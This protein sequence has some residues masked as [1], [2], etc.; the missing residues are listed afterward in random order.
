[1]LNDTPSD[2]LIWICSHLALS[3]V[4]SLVTVCSSFRKLTD[5]KYL[6]IDA[7]KSTGR[8]RSLACP[9]STD[10]TQMSVDELRRIAHRTHKLEYNWSQERPRIA[11]SAR[12]IQYFDSDSEEEPAEI[13]AV[14][15]G[16]LLVVLQH[17]E[18]ILVCDIEGQIPIQ[19]IDVGT[20][21]RHAHW[22]NEPECHLI[23]LI[24]EY[25]ED[26]IW[27]RG[28]SINRESLEIR[29]IFA[30]R[31]DW[32]ADVPFFLD[33]STVGFYNGINDTITIINFIRDIS[34]EI[35]IDKGLAEGFYK[36]SCSV[37]GQTLILLA[38]A[39]ED[40]CQVLRCPIE[41]LFLGE[42]R[43]WADIATEISTKWELV[44][45][46]P[47]NTIDPAAN[48][49][50]NQVEQLSPFRFHTLRGNYFRGDHY[51]GP[52]W[53]A[54]TYASLWP[55][56]KIDTIDILD[57][58]CK[59]SVEKTMDWKVWYYRQADGVR[60]PWL[61]APSESGNYSVIVM[62][63]DE[64]LQLALL[65]WDVHRAAI[66]VRHL[67]VPSYIDLNE[68]YAVGIEERYGV[69]YLSLVQGYLFA[70]PYA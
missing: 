7:L 5:S 9:P 14:I 23:A 30:I 42:P 44:A 19:S 29:E 39:Q 50:V 33:S 63:E 37:I 46:L 38:Y 43:S 49:Y 8:I 4:L 58:Q 68:V 62:E 12:S 3:D 31:I 47:C 27:L 35:V 36:C 15:P 20:L 34:A 57:G 16:T 59:P 51:R 48:Y 25:L 70:L 28:I 54:T 67:D 21:I 18:K 52:S 55:I 65:H 26:G 60:V 32:V 64:C 24:N 41:K 40:L 11:R 69:I 13:L 61:A 1:M 56:T 22:F 10:L 6:W 2:I 45:T 53:T 66:H 17:R